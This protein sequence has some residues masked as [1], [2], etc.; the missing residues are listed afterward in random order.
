MAIS[1]TGLSSHSGMA[2]C[3]RTSSASRLSILTRDIA[4]D[5]MAD[6]FITPTAD[7]AWSIVASAPAA[8]MLFPSDQSRLTLADQRPMSSLKKDNGY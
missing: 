7:L 6:V 4:H 5:Y 1:T 2:L 8:S 3:I